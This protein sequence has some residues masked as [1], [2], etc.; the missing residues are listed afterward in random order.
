MWGVTVDWR[1]QVHFSC[2]EDTMSDIP[3]PYYPDTTSEFLSQSPCFPTRHLTLFISI[4][5]SVRPAPHSDWSLLSDCSN[6]TCFLSLVQLLSRVQLFETPWT[7]VSQASLSITNSWILLKLMSIESVMPFNHLILCLPVLLLPSIFSSIRV[8]YNELVLCISWPEYWSFI[9]S[10]Q[11]IFRTDFHLGC[12]VWSPCSPWVSQKSSPTSQFQSI[13]FLCS[14]FFMV[15][16]S[17]PY[18][19]AGITI[20]WTRQT[21]VG[22]VRSAV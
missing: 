13:N 14:A 7:A 9:F 3:A 2:P 6:S 22:K 12:I 16:L 8:F 18:M 17:H 10:I 4:S 20:A 19:T 5:I 21:F 11:W 1:A 15:Q